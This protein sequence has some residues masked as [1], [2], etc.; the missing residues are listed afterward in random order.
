MVPEPGKEGQKEDAKAEAPKK[1][2]TK[3]RTREQRLDEERNQLQAQ[4]VTS[5]SARE[6]KLFEIRLKLNAARKRTRRATL[7]EHKSGNKSKKDI[8]KENR[9][10]YLEKRESREKEL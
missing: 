2:K 1:K 7:A 10:Q 8:A 5:M 4:D 3:K 9:K 6:K